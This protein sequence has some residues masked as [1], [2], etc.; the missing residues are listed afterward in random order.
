MK[1]P[2]FKIWVITIDSETVWVYRTIDSETVWVDNG[3]RV[4]GW[5]YKP[6]GVWSMYLWFK[7]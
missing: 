1:F 7:R 5:T 3:Q 4:D 2:D 6:E